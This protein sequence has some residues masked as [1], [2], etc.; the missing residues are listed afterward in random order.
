MEFFIHPRSG[1]PMYRQLMQQIRTGIA[2]RIIKAGERMPTVRELAL[3]LTIN[4][5]TVARAYRELEIEGLLHTAQGR[6][7]FVS[8]TPLALQKGEEIFKEKVKRVINEGQQLNL[9]KERIQEIFLQALEKEEIDSG[10]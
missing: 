4:P 2:A 1:V 5:N 7:T 9:S 8:K 6:G 3:Q 10:E